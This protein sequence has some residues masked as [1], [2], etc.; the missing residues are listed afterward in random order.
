MDDVKARIE[1]KGSPTRCPYCHDDCAPGQDEVACR[2][3]L[4]RHHRACWGERGACGSCSSTQALEAE[5]LDA[6]QARSVLAER[7]EWGTAVVLPSALALLA[8]FISSIFA[9]APPMMSRDVETTLFWAMA[10]S[11]GWSLLG[12]PALTAIACA[13]SRR[14]RWAVLLPLAGVL[15]W[16]LRQGGFAY[17]LVAPILVGL[18]TTWLARRLARPGGGRPSPR[19]AAEGARPPTHRKEGA[20]KADGSPSEAAP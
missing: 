16:L 13:F 18:L 3:C 5:T 8:M 9:L 7:G 4:A 15:P 19:P 2:E 1:V 20:A 12:I 17:L 14:Y 6:A 11:G 10:L